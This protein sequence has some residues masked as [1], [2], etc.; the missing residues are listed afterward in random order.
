MHVTSGMWGFAYTHSHC[1]QS[2]TRHANIVYMHTFLLLHASSTAATLIALR[3]GGGRRELA[4]IIPPAIHN[5]SGRVPLVRKQHQPPLAR[6]LTELWVGTG[7]ASHAQSTAP[8]GSKDL[9]R[10][11]RLS[12]KPSATLV[13]RPVAQMSCDVPS[14]RRYF[15]STSSLLP[16]SCWLKAG[17]SCCCSRSTR[18][19]MPAAS[20][21]A[22]AS[23]DLRASS[24]A[25]KIALDYT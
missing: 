22:M 17:A 2:A 12:V 21:R 9:A 3:H 14:G 6:H 4:W 7:S 19:E 5:G 16:T 20:R 24:S 13:T 10:C 1:P 23:S 8:P 18:S 11:D 15:H 25:E